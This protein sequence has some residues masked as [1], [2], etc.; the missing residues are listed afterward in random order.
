MN[1]FT[2][3]ARVEIYHRR[4]DNDP[5]YEYAV[6]ELKRILTKSKVEARMESKTA[7]DTSLYLF[8]GF[9]GATIPALPSLKGDL[10]PDAYSLSVAAQGVLISS[11][12]AKGILNG[13]YGLAEKLGYAFL[14]PG[15]EGEWAPESLQNLPL[16]QT[17]V[18]PRFR[19][20]GFFYGGISYDYTTEEWIVFY[21]KLRMNAVS[22]HGPDL[23]DKELP[24]RLG[25]RIETGGHGYRDLLPRPLFEK[26]PE[27]FRMGQ[28]EDF[29]GKRV[30]DF[31]SCAANLE[32]RSIMGKN[33]AVQ[34]RQA[35]Q[36][37][38]Y[39]LHNWPDD[40]PGGGWCLCPHCRSIAP[41]DQAMLAMRNLGDV[42]RA[43][44]LPMRV[45]MLAYHDTMRPAGDIPPSKETFLLFAPRER[46]YGHRLDDPQC[47]RNQFYLQTL[48]EWM[49]KFKGIDDAHTFEYY[50]DQ[51]LYRGLHPYIPGVIAGDMD[52]YERC[53][54]ESH[55]TL[56]IAGT[57][58]APD[59]NMLFFAR[60]LWNSELT[61][62]GFNSSYP[63]SLGD[64][65]VAEAWSHYLDVRARVFT[66]VLDMCDHEINIYLDYR[67]LPGTTK[68]FGEKMVKVYRESSRDLAC[69]VA[70]FEAAVSGQGSLRLQQLAAAEMARARF[71]VAELEVMSWQQDSV[72]QAAHYLV[73]HDPQSLHAAIASGENVIRAFKSA[74][75]LAKKAKISEKCWYFKN[76][77]RWIT[78]ETKCKVKEWEAE[79]KKLSANSVTSGK[80]DRVPIPEYV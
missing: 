2:I 39:A 50:C 7:P 62:D 57:A 56:H 4:L 53:G 16:G 19:H 11:T 58:V 61:G 69:A 60:N 64:G 77:N 73:C 20:R 76:V 78:D 35:A 43:E 26:K 41:S 18:N 45:P 15:E 79:A 34:L 10:F 47:A 59:W 23:I 31:N 66:E 6:S 52:V 48:I 3:P 38:F 25:F 32:A 42:V 75:A 54:I 67:W 46:C 14:L 80:A 36:D 8:V 68:P 1:K 55:M 40:L 30:S 33:F 24:K 63:A 65:A 28:P 29:G 70:Q 12:S 72:N 13:V 17:V 9:P 71:E 5:C 21:A 74:L 22:L 44:K 27:L 51:I 49:E 37:G